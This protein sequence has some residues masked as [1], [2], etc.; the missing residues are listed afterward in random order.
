[1]KKLM[2]LLLL[3]VSVAVFAQQ[4]NQEEWQNTSCYSKIQFKLNY[5]GK[6]GDRHIWKVQFRSSYET[7]VSFN[8][9]VSD[10]SG[11]Y[12]ATTHRKV[13]NPG[14]VSAEIETYTDSDNIFITV[15]KVS[16]SPYPNNFIDCE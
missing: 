15:D 14:I 5:V 13:L 12:E 2:S 7:V 10:E 1:M 9:H 11:Q 8:Y 3:L 6:N 16:L 4:N